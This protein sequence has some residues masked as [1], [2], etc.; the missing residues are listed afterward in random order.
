[1]K[2]NFI[3]IIFTM[4]V[5][6]CFSCGQYAWAAYSTY[7]DFPGTSI[8]TSKWTQQAT[9]LNMSVSGGNLVIS[10]TGTG[11]GMY[12]V[13]RGNLLATSALDMNSI[14][15]GFI[16]YSGYS[17]GNTGA[18]T[19]G[20]YIAVGDFDSTPDYYIMGRWTNVNNPYHNFVYAGH[21]IGSQGTLLGI[22]GYTG[23]SGKLGILGSESSDGGADFMYS[24][25]TDPSDPAASDWHTL[26][27]LIGGIEQPENLL[28]GAKAGN[29]GDMHVEIGGV[30]VIRAVPEPATML[31]L[32]L[33]LVG[34]AGI[35]RKFKK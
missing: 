15:G 5:I 33:G 1:M 4:A 9:S 11:S 29:N 35:R 17:S 16:T 28:I 27:S 7:D 18:D 32:G 2:K 20:V 12:G 25:S 30:Y 26:Y 31:L 13:P 19:A 34:L 6:V 21:V 10:G 24:Y 22:Y 23:A 14:Y 8:D 3:V